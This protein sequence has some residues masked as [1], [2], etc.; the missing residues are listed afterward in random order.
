MGGVDGRGSDHWKKE[1]LTLAC[2]GTQGEKVE[3]ESHL[4]PLGE[5][6]TPR[7]ETL[8]RGGLMKNKKGGSL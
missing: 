2:W 6:Y 1:V 7:G 5:E 8:S 4:P 3:K